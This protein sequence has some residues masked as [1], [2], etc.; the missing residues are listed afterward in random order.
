VAVSAKPLNK[1]YQ[2]AG[3]FVG[4]LTAE[5]IEMLPAGV[6]IIGKRKVVIDR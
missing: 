1:V 2:I 5:E 3:R 4:E 6:Y